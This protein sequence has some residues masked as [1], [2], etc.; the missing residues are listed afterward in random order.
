MISELL[1]YEI[2]SLGTDDRWNQLVLMMRGSGQRGPAYREARDHTASR[3]TSDFETLQVPCPRVRGW[4]WG[5]VIQGW[6]DSKVVREQHGSQQKNWAQEAGAGEIRVL[7]GLLAWGKRHS[8]CCP[9]TLSRTE[10]PRAF[11]EAVDRCCLLLCCSMQDCLV[12]LISWYYE[13][14]LTIYFSYYYY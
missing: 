10:P 5:Q 14:R 1:K 13:V 8:A 6:S 12:M 4:M 11:K 7:L 3:T 9:W 2:I